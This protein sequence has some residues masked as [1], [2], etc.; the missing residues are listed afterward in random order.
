MVH[1]LRKFSRA[2]AAAPGMAVPTPRLA[3]L[4]V[5]S[6]P[7]ADCG[8]RRIFRPPPSLRAFCGE[9]LTLAVCPGRSAAR[10]A[11]RAKW[12]AADTD[13]GFTRDRHSNARKSDKSDLRG[14][15]QKLSSVRS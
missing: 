3:V 10:S 5:Y 9:E 8:N 6:R 12:C 14:S 13:L 1:L 2:R 4:A 11:L 7:K 15:P